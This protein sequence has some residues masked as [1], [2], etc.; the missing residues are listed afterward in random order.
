[1]NITIG[2]LVKCI[3]AA[4]ETIVVKVPSS[5]YYASKRESED[6]TIDIVNAYNLIELLHDLEE[7]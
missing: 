2:Q 6:K 7:E 5:D 4:T 1:M 3:E